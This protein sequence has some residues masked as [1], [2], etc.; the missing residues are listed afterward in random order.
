MG[1]I[2]T[3][4]FSWRELLYNVERE[5]DKLTGNWRDETVI[6]ESIE[7]LLAIMRAQGVDVDEGEQIDATDQG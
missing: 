2:M 5:H 4:K 6:Q 7:T 1:W 3:G